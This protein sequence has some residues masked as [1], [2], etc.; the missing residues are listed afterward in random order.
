M[1]Y[2]VVGYPVE[3]RTLAISPKF[4]FKLEITIPFASKQTHKIFL[5]RLKS[6]AVYWISIYERFLTPKQRELTSF[7]CLNHELQIT[8][9]VY[10]H[11]H[12]RIA[13]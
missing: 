5:T 6:I 7:R 8:V 12:I 13:N 2:G 10:T 3:K 4:V 9:T 1:I 11:N